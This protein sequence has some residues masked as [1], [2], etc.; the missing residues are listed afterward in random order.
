VAIDSYANLKTAIGSW[1]N[2]ADS[3]DYADDA[4]DLFEAWA[5][6]NFR[7][8]EMLEEATAS[9]AE[10]LELPA[11][12]LEM[13]DLQLDG[14]IRYPLEYVTPNYADVYDPTSA[15]G[16]TP[17]YYTILNNEIRIIPAPTSGTVRMSYYETITPL[18]G[19]NT[20]NWLLESHPDAYLY[21]SLYHSRI[22]I[23][24]DARAQMVAQEWR[25]IAAEIQRAG[26]RSKFG[27]D[28]RIV[29]A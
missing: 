6:R 3:A 8:R 22:Y 18:D 28:L 25:Q 10:R 1:I 4:I 5:N 26:K 19:S 2:R 9:A 15:S 29:A 21:G 12:F 23:T 16:G 11:D 14:S 27:G 20:T 7:V 17:R 13:K 24:D